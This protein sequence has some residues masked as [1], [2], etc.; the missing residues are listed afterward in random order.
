MT[1]SVCFACSF[2]VVVVV[3]LSFVLFTF[4]HRCLV[5]FLSFILSFVINYNLKLGIPQLSVICLK[6]Q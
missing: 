4:S 5:Y 6:I 3:V 2:V 1:N